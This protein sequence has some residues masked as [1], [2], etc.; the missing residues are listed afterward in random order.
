MADPRS[1]L[2]FLL[3]SCSLAFVTAGY[4]QKAVSVF[5]ISQPITSIS[6]CPANI[7]SRA[8]SFVIQPTQESGSQS[9][10][11]TE[12]LSVTLKVNGS[13]ECEVSGNSRYRIFLNFR[14]LQVQEGGVPA[15]QVGV[16]EPSDL[17]YKIKEPDMTRIDYSNAEFHS[18]PRS[19]LFYLSAYDDEPS[20]AVEITVTPGVESE[21]FV[22][23]FVLLSE[24]KSSDDEEHLAHC[25]SLHAYL[26]KDV[27]CLNYQS[28][29]TSCPK[30]CTAQSA[31]PQQSLIAEL[32][33]NSFAYGSCG[34][35]RHFFK[36]GEEPEAE[37][38]HPQRWNFILPWDILGGIIG[39][40]VVLF[41]II[42]MS[43]CAEQSLVSDVV[44]YNFT[45]L[46]YID[47][48]KWQRME[49][50][51]P[52]RLIRYIPEC[53]NMMD[54]FLRITTGPDV[55]G[56]VMQTAAYHPVGR[57]DSKEDGF[58]FGEV[59]WLARIRAAAGRKYVL[60]LE[61][62][63][64]GENE[65]LQTCELLTSPSIA[66]VFLDSDIIQGIIY[67]ID[68]GTNIWDASTSTGGVP[69]PS[70]KNGVALFHRYRILW[71]ETLLILYINDEEILRVE[72]VRRIPQTTM[73]LSMKSGLMN[74]SQFATVLQD[75][76]TCTDP[77]MNIAH[78]MVRKQ[79]AAVPL[80]DLTD[81][82]SI[83]LHH[84]T[85]QRNGVTRNVAQSGIAKTVVPAVVVPLLA[86]CAIVIGCCVYWRVRK[87][88]HKQGRMLK[89]LEMR[90]RAVASTYSSMCFGTVLTGDAE[91]DQ[92]FLRYA[93]LMEVS[94]DTVELSDKILGKG[95][96]G[97]VFKGQAHCL[98]TIAKGPTDVAIKTVSQAADKEQQK[99]FADELRIMCKMGR[100]LN[101][102]NLLGVVTKGV[103][104]LLLE[105]CRFGSLLTYLAD[106]RDGRVYEQVDESG[107]FLAFDEAE[108]NEQWLIA[109]QNVKELQSSTDMKAGMLSTTDLIAFG[110]Q[111]ARG[112]EH[113]T[114]RGIIHRDLAARNV[115]VADNRILKISDFGLAKIGEATYTVSNL[116]VP[117]PVLWMPPEAISGGTFSHSSDVWSFGILLWEI[118]TL[119]KMP[120]GE[121]NMKQ[122]S[123]SGFAGL[124]QDGHHMTRPHGAPT[125][126]YKIME[127]CWTVNAEARPTFKALQK[128]LDNLFCSC[129][130]TTSRNYISLKDSN[131]EMY[132]LIDDLL[133]NQTDSQS[134]QRD[135]DV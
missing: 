65:G 73:H 134:D 126:V 88:R 15:Y 3:L 104:L 103:P 59:E 31:D 116:L 120:Y 107:A 13:E 60:S 55:R 75:H 131:A 102:V 7:D 21:A 40:S 74:E 8:G 19:D 95:E 29:M 83:L 123:I 113:L 124:L 38:H 117:L 77:G 57:I 122:L 17:G 127:L 27:Y 129:G 81:N 9:V 114:S 30:N 14:S 1:E 80:L 91:S 6:I 106:F 16:D 68:Q 105:Y 119:G 62:R 93:H 115:L 41:F 49:G 99:L 47:Y 82:E 71:T 128:R 39:G 36:C 108:M 67:Q 23:D 56:G 26:P 79:K 24:K 96:F 66:F 22:V 89:N 42:P 84:N 33:S 72:D 34:R 110:H 87:P 94:R 69:Y 111:I 48:V 28:E 25:D 53:A 121:L 5:D 10:Q 130:Q 43:T 63:K 50:A 92:R 97:V 54:G 125:D 18:R 44:T 37:I 46:T 76:V 35:E 78:I 86:V 101:V 45:D 12:T 64:C 85:N 2:A 135:A 58:V 100:H 132:Q 51:T 20:I 11:G 133:N 90:R 98:P 109:R 112:M 32:T 70:T 118:F 52:D 4:P 61:N